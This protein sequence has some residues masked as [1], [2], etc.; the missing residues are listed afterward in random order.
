MMP[1]AGAARCIESSL[2]LSDAAKR[3]F[4]E[5]H[6]LE[7]AERA[8]YRRTT[9][10]A[11]DDPGAHLDSRGERMLMRVYNPGQQGALAALETRRLMTKARHQKDS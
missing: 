5:A 10:F 4:G 7:I 6:V 3:H 1:L 11:T 2:A 9:S 8:N